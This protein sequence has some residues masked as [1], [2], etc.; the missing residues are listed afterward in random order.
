MDILAKVNLIAK[1][2]D[3]FGYESEGGLSPQEVRFEETVLVK[4]HLLERIDDLKKIESLL[5]RSI[6][7]DAVR[8]V[9][10]PASWR[11]ANDLNVK[12]LKI[13]EILPSRERILLQGPRIYKLSL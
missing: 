8:L 7:K 1:G 5:D 9:G 4:I 12:F 11:D 3:S 6:R 2:S 13:W 10:T